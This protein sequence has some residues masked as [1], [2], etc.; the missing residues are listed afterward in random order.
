[1]ALRNEFE[2]SGSWLFRHRSYLPLVMVPI[3]LGG[4]ASFQY[5]FDSHRMNEAWQWMCMGVSLL[6]VAV[7]VV[8]VGFVPV[9]TSG[10]NTRAQIAE[11]LNTTGAYS[12]VRHP[13]YLGN[14]LMV[15]GFVL[16][17]HAWWLVV[18]LCGV[19]ALYYERIMFA[20]EA[21]LRG[22]F[23]AEF[24]AW[25]ERTPAFIPRLRGWRA[26]ALRFSWRSVLRREYSSVMQVALWFFVLDT[27]ADSL[28]ERR[29][30]LEPAWL[31]VLGVGTAIYVV[32]RTLK[33]RTAVL[34]A[35]G[36]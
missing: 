16:F 31:A 1:V 6:G 36:R 17:F 3:F 26:P 13:L 2:S 34:D 10:R 32:L 9:G 15:L 4:L 5:L 23:G 20:E 35:P 33:R 22:K 28:M 18:V 25:A 29:L 12:L 7:R 30:V 14:F 11:T 21:Y 19:Y 27:L 8:T 24:E